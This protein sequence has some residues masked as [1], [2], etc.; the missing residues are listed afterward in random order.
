M[1]K[2]IRNKILLA[3]STVM[4][5]IVSVIGYISSCT[6]IN[7][8]CMYGVPN[9]EWEN[10]MNDSVDSDTIPQAESDSISSNE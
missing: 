8:P 2:K 7:Q 3:T 10:M 4:A 6:S 5:V 9:E 1:P